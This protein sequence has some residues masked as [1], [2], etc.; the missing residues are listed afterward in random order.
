MS[1]PQELTRHLDGLAQARVLC[2]GDVMLDRFMYGRVERISPEAPI[3]VFTQQS[4]SAMLGGA[5]NVVRNLLSLGCQAAF[6][7][8][9]GDDAVGNKVTSLVGDEQNLLPYLLAE[10]GR[11]TT[12][13]TRYVAGSQQL[14]RSDHETSTPIREETQT[15]L[16]ELVLEEL[17]NYQALILSDYGKGVLTPA[18]CRAVIDAANAREI[19][20]F[21]DPKARDVSVYAGATVL[22]PNL[23]ELALACGVDRFADDAAIIEAAR[24]LALTHR[25]RYVLVTRGEQGMT[26]VDAEGLIVHANAVAQEVFD[27]SGAGDTVI[28]TLAATHAA[29]ARMGQAAE[30]ANLAAGV[31]VGRLGTA[32]VHRTDL[33]AAIYAHRAVSLQQKILPLATACDVVANHK[34]EGLSV[35]FTNGCFDIMHAGHI[36]L[37]LDAKSRCDKL[38]VGLNTD[39]SVR[40]LKGPT[41]PVNAEMDRA[42]ILAALSMVDGVVL[43]DEETPLNLIRALQPDVLMKGADYTK[44]QVVGWELVESYGGR[45]ELIPLKDGYSTTGIIKKMAG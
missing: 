8:V 25:F 2:V 19:P 5:G 45:V 38:F 42:Q 30:L 28:A 17:P 1:S 29:G 27:V 23:K 11:I 13:K 32:V 34:R 44:E 36:S 20:V 15:R 39:A 18:L 37:L 26:L 22:S 9:I 3:P 4:E 35:G 10:R 12:K 14:L 41:R 40:G 33:T 21:V 6:A 24:S 16:R 43:F 31:V 7:S